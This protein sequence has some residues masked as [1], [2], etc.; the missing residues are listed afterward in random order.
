MRASAQER[1]HQPARNTEGGGHDAVQQRHAHDRA[2][3]GAE[4]HA[5]AD[6]ARAAAHRVG[7]HAVEAD[8]REDEGEH[9]EGADQ[10]EV[11][12]RGCGLARDGVFDALDVGDGER[13]GPSP[14]GRH[15]RPGARCVRPGASFIVTYITSIPNW[16]FG[17]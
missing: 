4:R 6:L 12:A 8:R 11:E 5:D 9:R 13:R 3:A 16:A 10:G 7:D 2:A 1:G 17:T 15:A 14:S